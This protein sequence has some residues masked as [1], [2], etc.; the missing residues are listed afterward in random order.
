MD[1]KYQEHKW[2]K[3]READT[4]RD[5]TVDCKSPNGGSKESEAVWVK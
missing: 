2:S 4:N 3:G 5:Y 1:R